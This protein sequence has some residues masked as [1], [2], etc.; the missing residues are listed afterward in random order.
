ME[1]R[2]VALKM[3]QMIRNPKGAHHV[4]RSRPNIV[5]VRVNRSTI[6]RVNVNTKTGPNTS[7]PVNQEKSPHNKQKLL[8]NFIYFKTILYKFNYKLNKI[9]ILPVTVFNIIFKIKLSIYNYKNK[10]KYFS[11]FLEFCNYKLLLLS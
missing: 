7:P 1:V 4:T 2:L 10:K 8:F 9:C 3:D 5:V 6:A 11:L